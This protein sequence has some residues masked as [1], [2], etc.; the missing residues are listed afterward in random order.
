MKHPIKIS[1]RRTPNV[2]LEIAEAAKNDDKVMAVWNDGPTRQIPVYTVAEFKSEAKVSAQQNMTSTPII[3]MAP[4]G[5]GKVP[6][7]PPCTAGSE[8]G[9]RTD[10]RRGFFSFSRTTTRGTR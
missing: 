7:A 10:R 3:R 9:Q 5:L 8:T 6:A 1:T 2:R 4:S